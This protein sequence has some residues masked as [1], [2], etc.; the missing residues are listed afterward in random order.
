MVKPSNMRFFSA[1]KLPHHFLLL[2]FF[3]CFHSCVFT[4]DSREEVEGNRRV[5]T[6]E[7][8]VSS[9]SKLKIMGGIDVLLTQA[10]QPSAELEGEENILPYVELEEKGDEL[11]IRFRNNVRLKTHEQVLVKLS[12][13]SFEKIFVQG[14]GEVK[15]NSV[16]KHADRLEVSMFGS[17]EIRLEVDAPE[18]E[19]NIS[20][21]GDIYLKG[22]TKYLKTSITGSGDFHL[23][24]LLSEEV[25]VKTTGS[26]DTHVFASVS[27]KVGITGSG[28]VTYGGDPTTDIKITGSGSVRKKT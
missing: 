15:G 8:T 2:L 24:N 10:D 13:P 3:T 22:R 6:E 21:S 11:I 12:M 25:Q 14:S 16:I 20:G 17:G 1:E 5:T 18:V 19:T 4:N 28:D 9:M 27:L 7:R 23:E 26:G